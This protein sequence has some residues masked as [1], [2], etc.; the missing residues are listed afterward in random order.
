M[1]KK[2]KDLTLEEAKVICEK[3]YGCNKCPLNFNKNASC[4]PCYL[5]KLTCDKYATDYQLNKEVKV[6]E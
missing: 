4:V 1:K 3:H 5:D 2:I 6:D